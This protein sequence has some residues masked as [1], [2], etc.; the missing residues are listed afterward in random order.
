M[1]SI[2]LSV[3]GM[4]CDHCVAK[5]QKALQDVDG[6]WGVFVELD[7][8]TAEVDFDDAKAGPDAL[9]QAV[10]AAGYEAAVG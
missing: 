8:G 5:V 1:A 6:V 2:K 4:T 7:G 3:S 9:T 10:K